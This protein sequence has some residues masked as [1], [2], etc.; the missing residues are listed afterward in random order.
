ML[1]RGENLADDTVRLIGIRLKL[2]PVDDDDFSGVV[3]ATKYTVIKDEEEEDEGDQ[4]RQCLSDYDSVHRHYSGEGEDYAIR[5]NVD[6][7]SLNKSMTSSIQ[8]NH[9]PTLATDEQLNQHEQRTNDDDDDYIKINSQTT[10]LHSTMT[11]DDRDMNDDDNED[12]D[13]GGEEHDTDRSHSSDE[14]R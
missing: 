3:H 11:N 6:N 5:S 7:G 12:D 10:V 13:G 1:I 14:F 9:C 8:H 2:T 4:P